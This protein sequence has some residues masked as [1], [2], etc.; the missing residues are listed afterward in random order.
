MY[1]KL[2]SLR[3]TIFLL[4]GLTLATFIFFSSYSGSTSFVITS[5]NV[6]DNIVQFIGN[7]RNVSKNILQWNSTKDIAL[8]PRFPN[9]TASI[10][11]SHEALN[12]TMPSKA[13]VAGSS[14]IPKRMINGWKT[15]LFWGTWFGSPWNGGFGPTNATGLKL[16]G[17]PRWKC[18]FTYDHSYASIADAIVFTAGVFNPQNFPKAPRPQFQRW[19]WVDV[20]APTEPDGLR[21]ANNVRV[22]H[23]SPLIN[24]TMT[25]H[26]ESDII[27]FHGYFLSIGATVRPLRP[28]LMS[29]HADA[30]RRYVEALERGDTLEKVMGPSWRSFVKR[31]KVVAWMSG[32]CPTNSK[33]EAY[34]AELSKYITV[35]KYG[36]CG[37]KPCYTR[38]PISDL[39]WKNVLMGNYSFYMSLENNLCDEY[40]TEKLYNPLLH[41]LVP[42]VYGGSDY[43][44]FLPPL[45]YINARHYHPRE[46]ARLL[47][48][49]HQDP[50]AYGRYHVWRGYF[51]AK[52]LGSMCE[53]CSRLHT[54]TTTSYHTDVP[55]WRMTSGRCKA[56]PY[57][58]FNSTV[59]KGAWRTIISTNYDTI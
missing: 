40:I 39:C 16:E 10:G 35:D 26:S 8:Y 48:R 49:L 53:L 19:V 18:N 15:I 31:P 50:V 17:C 32:H 28:N 38:H 4:S 1:C 44:R 22:H 34:V 23:T 59:G 57:N 9:I 25:Y 41:N 6:K 13:V 56:V 29:E 7:F 11:P 12:D 24:W 51:Q 37:D 58:M 43:D 27:A 5:N 36:G 20:E 54:D 3:H 30:M 46:L 55:K 45:S 42:I 21:T 14:K 33:R 47:T 2:M 52:I